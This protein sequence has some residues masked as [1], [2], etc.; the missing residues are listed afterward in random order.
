[1]TTTSDVLKRYARVAGVAMLLSLGFGIFGEM[2]LPMKLVVRGDAAA[3]AANILQ[4]PMLFRVSFATYLVEGICD[5]LLAVVFYIILEPVDR[6]L[7]LISAFF[8]VISMA[9]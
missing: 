6:N 9:M 3:T 8:G 4:H 1:M 7:A 2:I 5:V